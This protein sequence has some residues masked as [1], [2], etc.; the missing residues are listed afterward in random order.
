MIY[1]MLY[2]IIVVIFFDLLLASQSSLLVISF[3]GYRHDYNE[4]YEAID[5]NQFIDTGVKAKSLKPVFP[6]LTFPNHFS[7]A[8]GAL[9]I[10]AQPH[11]LSL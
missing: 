7:I 4:M 1:K 2:Q 11:E 8:T 6:T 10:P 9:K 3:D 5:F